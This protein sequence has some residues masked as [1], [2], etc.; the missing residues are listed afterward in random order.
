MKA[1]GQ[2][3]TSRASLERAAR[4]ASGVC[5]ATGLVLTAA[6][7]SS[8]EEPPPTVPADGPLYAIAT[9]IF[10]PDGESSVVTLVGD[11]T[12][13]EELDTRSGVEV[14]GSAALFGLDGSSAFALGGSETSFIQRYEVTADGRFEEGKRLGL[15]SQGIDSAFKLPGLVPFLSEDKAYFIDDVTE[16]I[17][18]WNPVEMTVEKSISLASAT[19][20]GWFLELREQAVVRDNLL[21][22]PG[23][24]RDADLGEAGQAL[25]LVVDTDTDELVDV[26]ED[27]RCGDTTQVVTDASGAL[28]FG[29]GAVAAVL[30]ALKRPA[31]YPAPCILRILPGERRFDPD[32]HVALPGLVEDRPAGRLVAGTEGRAYVLA[33]HA[34]LLDEELGPS[35]ELWA[36]WDAAAWR[37]WQ[38][39]LGASTPGTLVEGAPLG[40]A[41]GSVLR[42]DGRDHIQHLNAEE[43]STMLLTPQADGSLKA[44]LSVPG[45]PYG[46]VRVR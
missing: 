8:T 28:Y 42:S 29:S 11:P 10:L 15:S 43:G 37:W 33:L 19:R 44:G 7:S 27:D 20:E 34:E 31:D 45:L 40:S 39:E 30:H 17:V 35:T 6:C 14:G 18:V 1:R 25:A 5:V 12:G 13:A 26:L 21:F 46:L 32:F 41:A 4:A 23:R 16:Q 9:T 36:P 2:V 3:T 38:I 22:I 24:F